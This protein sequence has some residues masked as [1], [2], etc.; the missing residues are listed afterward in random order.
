ME[1]VETLLTSRRW[2]SSFPFLLALVSLVFL[3]WSAYLGFTYSHDG[4]LNFTQS[5]QITELDNFGKDINQFQDGDRILS[6]EGVPFR[7]A[8]PLYAGLH[9]GDEVE[10]IVDRKGELI[11]LTVRLVD[12][13]ID[14]IIS[15][16][17]VLIIALIF[18]GMG[19]GV[20]SFKPGDITSNL[21]FLFTQDY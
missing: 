18:W 6:V 10:F 7:E 9:A 2:W 13:P 15:G 11:S 17:V 21:F 5:G 20:L 1:G 4:I 14:V 19:V 12:P 3:G 16:A 8:I